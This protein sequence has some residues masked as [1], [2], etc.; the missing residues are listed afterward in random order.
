[1]PDEGYE[2]LSGSLTATNNL[3]NE[4]IDL[5]GNGDGTWSFTM[6]GAQVTVSATFKKAPVITSYVD[7]DGVVHDNVQAIPL[8]E[9]MT[10]L[11]E[12]EQES[13]YVAS[14]TLNYT[15]TLT[16]AGDV[17]LI[18]ADGA[19]M[20]IGTEAAPVSGKGIDGS[21]YYSDFTIYGQTLDDDTAGH[22]NINT[23]KEC[24]EVAGDYAQHSGNVTANS[25][26]E[27]GVVPWYNF[28]FT[29]GTLYITAKANAIYTNDNVDILGGKLS[30]VCVGNYFGINSARGVATIGWKNADDEFTVSNFAVT[31]KI[32]DGQA[33]TDGENIYDSTTPSDVLWALTNVTLRPVATFAISLPESFEHG[34]VSCDKQTAYEGQTVTLTVKP[35]N[36]YELETLTVTFTNE[37]EP[38]GAPLRLRGGSL[39]LTPGENGT[40]TFAMPAQPVTVNATFKET[41]ITGVEDI[42]AAQPK[43]GQ[44]FNVMGQPVGKD[45]KGIVIEDGKKLIVR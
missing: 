8:D 4:A 31:V 18:L 30:A 12:D 37:N 10:S 15:Q 33:F 38:S 14:G 17:H 43:S 25:V 34:T 20:N 36:G 21:D 27:N 3:S 11:G 22:L 42:N 13:W 35:D 5:T 2:Y 28:A 9:T 26:N 40:Y 39:E 7:A 6:P 16:F 24:I 45:Y 29:G 32:V 1:M 19:V 44:R 41:T 23:D